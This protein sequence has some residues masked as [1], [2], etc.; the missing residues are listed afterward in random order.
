MSI[1]VIINP[2]SAH[3]KTQHRWPELNQALQKKLGAFESLHTSA[4]REATQLTRQ[5]LEQGAKWIF[6]VGGDGTLNEV[7][8][9]FFSPTGNLINPQARLS[10]LMSGTGSDFV[11][12]LQHPLKPI[13]AL[14]QILAASPRQIDLGRARL[15]PN[16][17][18]AALEHY[19]I[20]MASFGLGGAVIHRL[21]KSKFYQ[22]INGRAAFLL[23]TLESL[24][25]F[26][27]KPVVLRIDETL[28]IRTRIQQVVIANGQFQGGGMRIA[29]Q[30]RIDDGYF[31]IIILEDQPLLPT[32]K[33]FSKVYQGKH[34]DSGLLR[35]LQARKLEV[36]SSDDALPK[37]ELDG[38]TP[39]SLPG[40]FEI[41]PQ[42]LWF[43]G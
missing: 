40:C 42:A 31:E 37:L 28:E 16:K 1:T 4:P 2:V 32:L 7:V 26:K 13:D 17:D 39:G 21:Q 8:N 18:Q 43:Q 27:S 33:A 19:F 41:L 29:P 24:A 14:A 12:T 15:A 34:L 25:L 20:N 23:S 6:A 5:A 3:G 22:N 35:H 11:R 38:E 36:I 10:V 9:G 30:A